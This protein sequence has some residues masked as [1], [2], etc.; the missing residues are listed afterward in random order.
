MNTTISKT[1]TSPILW[2]TLAAGILDA[3]AAVSVYNYFYGYGPLQVYQFVASALLGDKAY[4]GGLSS[5]FFGLILHFF[6]AF[7]ASIAFYI[8][9]TKFSFL[10]NYKILAGLLYGIVVWAVMNLLVLPMTKI[11]AAEFDM[12]SFIAIIWHMIFVGLPI[13]LII[14]HYKHNT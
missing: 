7:M 1:R 8:G 11:P 5:A 14:N 3:I 12:V 2:S 6:I 9:F 13:S 10:R 4:Q